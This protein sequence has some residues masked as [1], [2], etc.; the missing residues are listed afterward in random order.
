[1]GYQYKRIRM[2]HA[3]VS[4]YLDGTSTKKVNDDYRDEVPK[5]SE[6]FQMRGMIFYSNTLFN[7]GS[8]QINL[9]IPFYLKDYL[10]DLLKRLKERVYPLMQDAVSKA[11]KDRKE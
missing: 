10:P 11:M 7:A 2:I 4:I 5:C 9:Y 8:V 6:E 3:E 1:M